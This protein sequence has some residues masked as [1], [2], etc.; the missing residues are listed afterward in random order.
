MLVP[1]V[2]LVRAKDDEE[3]RSSGTKDEGLSDALW[4]TWTTGRAGVI[5]VVGR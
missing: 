4:L 2:S 3:G 5:H 1:V